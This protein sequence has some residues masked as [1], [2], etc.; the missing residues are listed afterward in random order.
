MFAHLIDMA[1]FLTELTLFN[2]FKAVS[3]VQLKFSPGNLLVAIVALNAGVLASSGD[4][5]R[6]WLWGLF[7]LRIFILDFVGFKQGFHLLILV[8]QGRKLGHAFF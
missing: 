6:L 1:W 3:Q 5:C 8:F 2:I 7:C 4:E